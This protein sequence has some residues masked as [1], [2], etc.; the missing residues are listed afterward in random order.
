MADEIAKKEETAVAKANAPRR[1]LEEAI[2]PSD[3]IIPR[4]MLIQNTPPKTVQIDKKQCPPGTIIN[5]L[6]AVPLP[7]NDKGEIIFIP[8]IRGTK[9]IRFNAQEAKINGQ[10]NPLFDTNFQPGA[11]IWESKDPSDP[12]V[13]AEA[14]W[15]PNG[16]KP[17]AGKFIEF[18][19]IVIGEGMPIVIGFAK[20]SFN[21]GKNLSSMA[22]FS[23]KPD[24]FA[25][26][27]R[28]SSQEKKNPQQQE[29]YTLSVSK[30]GACTEEE[31]LE[32]ETIYNNFYGK[33]LKVHG[34][35]DDTA[36][37]VATKQPWE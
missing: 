21:A 25:F 6:T 33:E 37:P 35:E 29:Y 11:K 31:F 3:L 20:T 13:I 22:Q 2:D 28:L 30:A 10:P 7:T 26:K 9:W 16:E 17:L 18:L 14:A 27:Y 1:G 5:T 19:S 12:R 15:G 36:E 24:L 32:A 8:I 4:T 23:G 34:E